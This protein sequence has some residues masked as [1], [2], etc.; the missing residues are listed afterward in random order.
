ML[1]VLARHVALYNEMEMYMNVFGWIYV[2]HWLC[3]VNATLNF[4]PI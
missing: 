1:V 4:L 2:F 3:P